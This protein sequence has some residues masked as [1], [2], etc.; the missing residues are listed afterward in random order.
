MR[1]P[2]RLIPLALASTLFLCLAPA[3]R[4]APALYTFTLDQSPTPAA[5]DEALAAA[6][7]QGI[8]NRSSPQLYLLSNTNN[9]P[10]YWLD[11]LAQHWPLAARPQTKA[12]AR[13]YRAGANSPANASRAPSSG[14]PPSPPPSTSPPP[15]P[16]FPTRSCSARNSPTVILP[17]GGLP[18]LAGFARKIHRRGNRQREK[19]RLSLGHPRVFGQRSLLPAPPLSF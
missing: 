11:L 10:Q 19:R 14:T 4:A 16:V 12:A 15:A 2:P 7:L 5:Y 6:T 8:I 9:R 17:S 13:P 3:T 1:I 18:V